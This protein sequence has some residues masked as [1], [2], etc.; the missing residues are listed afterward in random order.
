MMKNIFKKEVLLL[1]PIMILIIFIYGCEQ[2][3][4]PKDQIMI[5]DNC[6]IDNNLNFV[7]DID[8]GVAI[9]GDGLCELGNK[10]NCTVCWQD[11]SACKVYKYV[12]VPGNFSLKNLTT[13]LNTQFEDDLKFRKDIEV[14]DSIADFYYHEE[15]IPRYLADFK[16][17]K[18]HPKT[19]TK[20]AVLSRIKLDGW[21]LDQADRLMNFTDHAKWYMIKRQILAEDEAYNRRILSNKAKNDYP[22]PPTGID[23]LNK[24]NQWLVMNY[25]IDENIIYDN[26]TLLNNSMVF[27]TFVSITDFDIL[28]RVGNY[29]EKETQDDELF[30]LFDYNT[31]TETKLSYVNAITF[32]CARNL[33]ITL[34][35]YDYNYQFYRINEDRIPYE[36]EASKKRLLS[37]AKKIQNLCKNKYSASVFT[38]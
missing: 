10:E 30:V 17:V 15:R 37:K 36:V 16:D 32:T 27:Q 29:T 34:F 7:C 11:C 38:P 13:A 2:K 18:Y 19:I 35:D 22:L 9:C 14:N 4:C 23:R 33:A 5:E 28:Y 3:T 20:M 24:Y 12:Y 26:T 21:Y 1:I 6:C 8:E 31:I 25:T